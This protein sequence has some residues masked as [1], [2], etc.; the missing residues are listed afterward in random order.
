MSQSKFEDKCYTAIIEKEKK[1]KK[2]KVKSV[3]PK[4]GS[5]RELFESKIKI[6]LKHALKAT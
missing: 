1:V 4:K 5:K 2:I 3:K 6:G